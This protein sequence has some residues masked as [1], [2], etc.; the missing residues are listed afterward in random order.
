MEVLRKY[1]HTLT[2]NIVFKGRKI[3]DVDRLSN[4]RH[5]GLVRFDEK[6]SDVRDAHTDVEKANHDL[7]TLHEAY[8]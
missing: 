7:N 4:D 3:E 5:I 6:G 2:E 1:A 8:K